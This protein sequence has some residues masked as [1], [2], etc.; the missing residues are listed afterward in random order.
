MTG[1]SPTAAEREGRLE[2]MAQRNRCHVIAGLYT[3]LDLKAHRLPKRR[4]AEWQVAVSVQE[5]HRIEP[6]FG[7]MIDTESGDEMR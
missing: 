5:Q 4:R 6:L 7:S 3:L 2:D 1:L